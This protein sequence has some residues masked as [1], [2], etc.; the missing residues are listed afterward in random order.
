MNGLVAKEL[1]FAFGA[2]ISPTVLVAELLVLSQPER[3]RAK[4]AAFV[5]GGFTVL[6]VAA[7]LTMTVL[8]RAGAKPDT[9]AM[10][11]VDLFFAAVLLGVAVRWIVHP[12]AR[13]EKPKAHR[14]GGLATFAALGVVIM[15][16]NV[17][18]LVLFMP[19][20]RDIA[21]A[22]SPFDSKATAT[23]VVFV[24]TTTVLWLPLLLSVM[25]PH[26]ADRV[27]QPVNR[28]LATH[29][30]LVTIVVSLGFAVFLGFKGLSRL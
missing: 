18:T 5:A 23:A 7:V 29:T 16:T 12:P 2:A 27:L 6:V 19:A 20:M 24:I 11:W 25:A 30:R 22:D 13:D 10:A 28:F 15:L 8:Q 9:P 1:P 26:T 21:I 14:Q 3:P 17:T 4:A